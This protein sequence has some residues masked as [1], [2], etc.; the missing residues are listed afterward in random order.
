MVNVEVQR[1]KNVDY[2]SV[3]GHSGF[4]D[5]GEDIVCAGVSALVFT[6]ANKVMTISKEC[7]ISQGENDF[8]F[9]NS[10]KDDKVNLLLD[11][12]V[13]GLIAI[14]EEY[15]KNIKIVEV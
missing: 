8:T 5:S 13:D 14:E 10:C 1:F 12:L 15:P 7:L 2:I 4:A 3:S 11:T 6:I 9:T